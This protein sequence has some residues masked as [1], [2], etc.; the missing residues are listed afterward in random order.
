MQKESMM[1]NEEW[2]KAYRDGFSDGYA[3]AKKEALGFNPYGTGT[4]LGTPNVYYG[5][6]SNPVASVRGVP[7]GGLASKYDIPDIP[8]QHFVTGMSVSSSDC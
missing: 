1:I 2:K 3:Q 6:S 7:T 4:V 8:S 5:T